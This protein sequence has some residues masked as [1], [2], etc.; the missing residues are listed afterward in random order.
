MLD[1]NGKPGGPT[2][3]YFR[4]TH[5][6]TPVGKRVDASLNFLW[7]KD[8]P[9][10]LPRLATTAFDGMASSRPRR[11]ETYKFKTVSDDGVRLWIDDKLVIDNWTVHPAATNIASANFKA[12][13]RHRFRMEYFQGGGDAR[14]QS[15]MRY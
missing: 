6:E 9:M 15:H 12:N 5:F 10:G 3:Q 7:T 2:G 14:G 8:A 4:G 1:E 11:T 13:T